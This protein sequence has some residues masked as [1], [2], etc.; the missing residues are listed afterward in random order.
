MSSEVDVYNRL[1]S[2]R[3]TYYKQ[4]ITP[5]DKGKHG[6]KHIKQPITRELLETSLLSQSLTIGACTIESGNNLVRSP[7]FD[8]DNHD[9]TANIIPDIKE[10]YDASIKTGYHPVIEASSGD[11]VN[12]GAHLFFP[13]QPTQAATARRALQAILDATGLK[14]EINPKQTEVEGGKYGNQVKLIF[15]YNNRTKARSTIINPE[16]MKPFARQD[17]INYLMALP[18]T[19]FEVKDGIETSIQ[20]IKEATTA[21]TEPIKSD[22]RQSLGFRGETKETV[23]ATDGPIKENKNL[24]EVMTA[25]KIKPCI[26][27]CYNEK[28]ALHG[29]GD[30]GHVFRLAAAG[31]LIYDGIDDKLVHE[32]F[33]IQSDYSKIN[34]EKGI[35]SAHK[36]LT[37][38]FNKPTGC[39]KLQ[40]QCSTLLNGMCATCKNNPKER[41]E[42]KKTKI[43]ERRKLP[44]IPQEMIDPTPTTIQDGLNVF[45]EHLYIEEAFSITIPL[46][47]VIANFSPIEPDIIGIIGASGSAKTEMIRA[48]GE[49]ENQFCYPVSSITS[50]TLVSGLPENIDLAPMLRGRILTIKDLTTILSKNKDMVSEIFADFRELT[51]GHIGK[52]FGSGVK[53]HYTGIHSSV[54]FGCTNAIEAHNSIFSV[55]GQRILFFR[56]RNDRRKS[57]EKA[58]S[59]N[60]KETEI[61]TALHKIT[62]QLINTMLTKHKERLEKLTQNISKEYIQDIGDLACFMAIVRTHISRDYRGDMAALPEPEY[63]TRLAK[64]MCKLVDAHS[65]LYDREPTDEDMK[66]AYRLSSDNIP[67]ERLKVLIVL[68]DGEPKTTTEVQ[69]LAKIPTTT[70]RRILDDLK[71]L[72]ILDFYSMGSGKPDIY[73]LSNVEYKNVLTKILEKSKHEKRKVS[74]AIDEPR[75]EIRQGVY[76]SPHDPIHLKG[77]STNLLIKEED[78]NNESSGFACSHIS[79]S[80]P[81]LDHDA[82]PQKKDLDSKIAQEIAFTLKDWYDSPN[83]MNKASWDYVITDVMARHDLHMDKALE[84]VTAARQKIGW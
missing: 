83:Q 22:M 7:S 37:G 44:D 6:Y 12:D 60:G 52:D 29:I 42:E 75:G 14:H 40:E 46:S 55:L 31:N 35:Q 59:N 69:T 68:L 34:T 17:A 54:L 66:V 18:D 72:E 64:T 23:K 39:K 81:T 73:Q 30:E 25:K 48:L 51:D 11:N 43:K 74:R 61:R 13:C 24:I 67:T 57:M 71:T 4:D 2:E 78:L 76:V 82:E 9:G 77:Y 65:I 53:K 10:L 1:I 15:Q 47:E 26:V 21:T 3:K 38:G 36:H 80:H 84:Y 27:K 49:M 32:Y 62:L 50:H 33:K 8:I 63:P 56:P 5:N 20:T 79:E 19:V 70:A 16:T 28:W 41:E 58:I 45:D